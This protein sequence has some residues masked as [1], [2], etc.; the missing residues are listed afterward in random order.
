MDINVGRPAEAKVCQIRSSFQ[1][2]RDLIYPS[3]FGREG[4]FILNKE[5]PSMPSQ[6]VLEAK[7]QIVQGLMEEF[8][9]AQA[10]VFAD[11]RGLTVE[12][13][14]TLRN[15]LRKAGVKYQVV[16]NTMS[17]RALSAAGLDNL[18]SILKGPTAIAYSTGDVVAPAKVVKEF[19]DKYEK[20][21]I[22]GGILEGK[23]INVDEVARLAAIPPKEVLYG[24][25]V[26]GL[27]SPIASLAMILNAV[28]EKAEAAGAETA[29]AV[30]V[31]AEA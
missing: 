19:A 17:V 24:Q 18:D 25:I 27:I 31:P 21:N 9:Q 26:C 5:V 4:Y 11:Y 30:A 7:K 13:D 23:V 20:L 14:T 29:A 1:G 3:V 6:K 12:Q 22:K 16:K 15:A 8:S 2:C 28:R 10:M